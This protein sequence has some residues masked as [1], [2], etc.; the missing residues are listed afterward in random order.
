MLKID[1]HETIMQLLN[2]N[3]SL[4]VSDACEI[5]G[6][7]DQTI[8]RDFQE[9][10]EQGKLKRIHGGAFIPTPE[11]KG[12][13]AKIRARLIVREKLRM[14]HTAASG[15]IRSN[16]LI[17]LDSSTTC[18]TLARHIL[19]SGMSVTII[20]NSAGIISEFE[21]GTS[22]AHL[23]CIGGRYKESLGAFIGTD[24]VRSISGYVA[25]KAFISCN[26]IDLE[27]GMLDNYEG[28]MDIRRAMLEHS[29]ER[30]L[31]VDHTKFGDQA[32]FIIGD[33]SKINGIITDQQPDEEWMD[34][35]RSLGINVI[36]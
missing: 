21:T 28:Q 27:H 9:L 35:F 22:S 24:A 29:R 8:R 19:E 30:Y 18:S 12:V 32:D 17:M 15:F 36:W 26:A 13:P 34:R 25:D 6:C 5:M 31:L 2:K 7:S 1:R 4:L 14:A 23:I 10:E 3:G 11:D 20:T 33:F 16:D